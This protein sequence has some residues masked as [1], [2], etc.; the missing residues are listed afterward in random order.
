MLWARAS[1]LSWLVR[2]QSDHQAIGL[3]QQGTVKDPPE[4]CYRY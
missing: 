4:R 1:G 2:Q 3:A